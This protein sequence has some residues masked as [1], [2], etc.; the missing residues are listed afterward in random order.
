MKAIIAAM[1][2]AMIKAKFLW[3]D[4]PFTPQMVVATY[5]LVQHDVNAMFA[6]NTTNVASIR[7][8]IFRYR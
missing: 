8:N 2:A 7:A 6:A 3:Y 1:I 4:C 5:N